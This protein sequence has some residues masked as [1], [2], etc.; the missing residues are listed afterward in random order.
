MQKYS[1]K[2]HK[3]LLH[4]LFLKN[5][6]GVPHLREGIYITTAS[7][8]HKGKVKDN[9]FIAGWKPCIFNLAL[10]QISMFTVSCM[11]FECF[12]T[13]DKPKNERHEGQA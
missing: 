5:E 9:M 10:F 7:L 12:H 2:E 3:H 4:C 6:T 11:Y 13:K 8:H 1:D